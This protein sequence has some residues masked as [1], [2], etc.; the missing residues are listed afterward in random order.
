MA[1]N[2]I[3]TKRGFTIIEVVLVLAIAGLIFLMVFIALPNMQRSQRDSQR[4]QDYAALGA[5]IM[6]Y[7]ANNN[8]NLPAASDAGVTL[9]ANSYINTTGKDQSGN[10]YTLKAV[11]CSSSSTA[12]PCKTAVSPLTSNT[13]A[14][15][16]VVINAECDSTAQGKAKA[17]TSG[18]KYAIV[19]Q[20]ETGV[21]CQNSS[22]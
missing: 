2:I 15:V 20:L 14:Q 3:N 12:G 16:W 8:G 19:G 6:N 11:T 7:I 22:D 21:Y 1:K 13:G 18:R 4:R 5:N 9:A 17:A 10:S